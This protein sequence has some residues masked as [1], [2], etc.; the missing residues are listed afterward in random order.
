MQNK[1]LI[2]TDT[3]A[4]IPDDLAKKHNIAVVPAANI[5]F[6]G[7]QYIDGV[8]LSATEAYELIKKDPD[9]FMT[10]ALSPAFLLEQYRKLGEGYEHILFVILSSNLSAGF[11]TAR[12]AADLYQSESPGATVEVLDSKSC[13]SSQGLTALAAAKAIEKGLDFTRVIDYTTKVRDCTG[14]L[15]LLDTLRYVYRTGRISKLGS[16]IASMFNIKPINRITEEGKIEMVDR[17]RNRDHGLE[18]LIDLIRKQSQTGALHFMVTHAT[19]PEG[20]DLLVSMLRD[21]FTCL[22]MVVN[23]FS[24]VMGYGAGP[25]TLFVGFHPDVKF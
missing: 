6:D 3:V 14:G 2:M 15:M 12:L 9:K 4:C 13:A 11:T 20:A 16:K 7:H 5:L 22:D 1:I 25:G 17:T 10:S 18:I 8:T 21:R 24:P 23:D 19:D